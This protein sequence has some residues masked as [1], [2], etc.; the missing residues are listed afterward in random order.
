MTKRSS[1]CS[2]KTVHLVSSSA[3]IRKKSEIRE[4]QL[5]GQWLQRPLARLAGHRHARFQQHLREQRPHRPVDG[6]NPW[7]LL[8]GQQY[9]PVSQHVLRLGPGC[10]LHPQHHFGLHHVPPGVQPVHALPLSAFHEG[11]RRDDLPG[12]RTPVPWN[13]PPSAPSRTSV[14]DRTNSWSGS[15]RRI[16]ISRKGNL[17]DRFGQVPEGQK[18]ASLERTRSLFVCRKGH[19]EAFRRFLRLRKMQVMRMVMII[20]IK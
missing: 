6:G 12:R 5:P 8:G 13:A 11:G 4:S 20:L 15:S 1:G 18:T 14:P 3:N 10:L 16:G 2:K 19:Q 17:T 7:A 9:L